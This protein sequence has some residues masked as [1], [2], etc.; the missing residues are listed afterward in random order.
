MTISSLSSLLEKQGAVLLARREYDR[1][2]SKLEKQK[3]KITKIKQEAE[4]DKIIAQGDSELE[5]N[6]TISADSSKSALKQYLC[7]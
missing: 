7:K 2:Q 6:K 1:L 5:N 4:V 3:Q